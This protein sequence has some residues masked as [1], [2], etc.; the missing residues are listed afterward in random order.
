MRR[1]FIGVAVIHY[2]ELIA[3]SDETANQLAYYLYHLTEYLLE[4]S[5]FTNCPKV[6]V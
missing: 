1:K 6:A 5:F 2:R 3:F 4:I